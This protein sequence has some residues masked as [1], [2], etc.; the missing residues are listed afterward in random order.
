MANVPRWFKTPGEVSTF[1]FDFR[2]R[3]NGIRGAATD[4]LDDDENINFANV[5]VD[6]VG[7]TVDTVT[8][9]KNATC[10]RFRARGGV[11]GR[12]YEATCSITTT[13]GRVAQRSN[14]ISV[15]T[16]R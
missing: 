14:R 10:V 3:T 5:V 6:Q 7:L 13:D 12:P 1:E 11:V 2:P 4:Y 9:I 15:V 8:V 16:R